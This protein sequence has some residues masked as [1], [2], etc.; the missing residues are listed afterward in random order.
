M[1]RLLVLR[2]VMGEKKLLRCLKKKLS[3]FA[4]VEQKEIADLTFEIAQGEVKVIAGDTNITDF[5][6]VW[7]RRASSKFSPVA[8]ALSFFLDSQ[9]IPYFDKDRREQGEGWK[10]TMMVRLGIAGL[11]V[12]PTFF[13][14]RK[15]ILAERKNIV[16]R[17]GF[18]LVA[19]VINKDRGKGVFLL[20][21]LDDFDSLLH[22]TP[23]EDQ[24]LFEKFYNNDGDY[25]ILVL[26]DEVGTWEKRTRV[27]DKYRNNACLGGKEEFF[28]V[29][30]ISKEMKKISL[31]AAK[32]L[33]LQIAGVDILV[34]K[35]TGKLWLLEVNRC[36]GFTDNIRISPELPVV[37]SFFAKILKS[38]YS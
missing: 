9:G 3:S 26:R 38:S 2:D 5:N 22:K 8:K 4:T 14:W 27:K 16:A 21:E 28:P 12:P 7:I 25:R 1:K 18:P 11:P 15:K 19:K 10:L 31:E 36:P 17:F 13:C 34:E 37:S 29:E 30:K 32:L 24:F 33:N 20:E 35:E 23:K 6:L